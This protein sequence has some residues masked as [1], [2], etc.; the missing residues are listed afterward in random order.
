MSN[1]FNNRSKPKNPLQTTVQGIEH[2][3][4]SSTIHFG[5]DKLLEKTPPVCR[6][7]L[8]C[9]YLQHTKEERYSHPII[10][11]WLT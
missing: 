4:Q 8:K 11:D 5:S 10:Q 1:K 2:S 9:P 3:Y 6:A 7:Q